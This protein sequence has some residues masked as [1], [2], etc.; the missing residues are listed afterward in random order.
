MSQSRWF[1][2]LRLIAF[3]MLGVAPLLA[4][5]QAGLQGT[6]QDKSGA[7]VSGATV[8]ATEND[9]GIEHTTSSNTSGFYRISQLPPGTYTVNVTAQGF[10]NSSYSDVIVE[11]ETL[12]G[13]DITVELG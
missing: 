2:C 9:T 1:I 8:T 6:I 10:K 4:Q 5:F 12:R 13:L 3:L 7:V 11:A